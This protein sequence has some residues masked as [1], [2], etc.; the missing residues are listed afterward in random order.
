MNATI[1]P[2][3]ETDRPQILQM[4]REFYASDMVFTNGS[5][6][7]YNADIDSCIGECPFVEGYV[8]DDG[9]NIHGY[10][11]VAKSFSTEFGKQCIWIEDI[12]IKNEFR[13]FGTGSRFLR[14]IEEKYPN[15]IFRLDVENSNERA[16]SVYKKCGYTVLPYMEMKK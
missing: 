15:A 12:Y 13:G 2:I 16:V 6:K 9:N 14:Y 11:M 10:A 3:K 5:E 1:R 8:F 4:M 7:I